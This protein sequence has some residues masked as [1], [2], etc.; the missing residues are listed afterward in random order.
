MRAV[1]SLDRI[2]GS[3]VSFAKQ[4]KDKNALIRISIRWR[5]RTASRE[6]ARRQTDTSS[7]PPES[8]SEKLTGNLR[9]YQEE[10][11]SQI[12]ICIMTIDR[13]SGIVL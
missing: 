7:N 1:K 9:R 11:L 4:T 5:S 2:I 8:V 12:V 3:G 10:R 13:V 6:S